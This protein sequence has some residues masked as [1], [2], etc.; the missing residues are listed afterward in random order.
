MTGLAT[1]LTGALLGVGGTWLFT[2]SRG[3]ATTAVAAQADDAT[4]TTTR[5]WQ[6]PAFRRNQA[7]TEVTPAAVV[8]ATPAVDVVTVEADATA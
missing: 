7:V 8:E 2:R 4:A 6:M 5:R 1:L 3:S